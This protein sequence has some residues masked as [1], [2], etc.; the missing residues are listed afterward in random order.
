MEQKKKAHH[1]LYAGICLAV[2][3]VLLAVDQ[4]LKYFVLRDLK[5]AGSVTV[6]D[7]LLELAY[8]ENTGAAFG[9]FQNMMWLLI[10]ITLAAFLVIVV[11]LFRYRSHTFFSYT[12]STLLIAG[13]IGNLLDRIFYGFVVDY[14][15]VLFFDYIFNFADCCVTV[16]TVLFIIH[17]V[18]ISVRE[19][20]TETDVPEALEK[21]E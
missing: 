8:I 12:A 7:G 16:G 15:H 1:N 18:L 9:L 5:P 19:K 11:L 20:R 10:L 21:Q 14:I 4:I 13:G 2:A 6:I 17:V 3:A